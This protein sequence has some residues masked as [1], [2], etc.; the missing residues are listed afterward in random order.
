MY[1]RAAP[2]EIRAVK[3]QLEVPGAAR[4]RPAGQRYP[5][6]RA[7][8]WERGVGPAGE[9]LRAIGHGRGG[10][11][12]R[13]RRRLRAHRTT[14]RTAARLSPVQGGRPAGL[15]PRLPARPGT[16]LPGC[17]LDDV[18]AA[19]ASLLAGGAAEVVPFGESA[20]RHPG[21]VGATC[22]QGRGQA[23]GQGRRRV[24]G[25]RPDPFQ[26]VIAYQRRAGPD[27][28][29]RAGTGLYPVPGG[30]AS[31]LR[32]SVTPARRP[33]GPARPAVGGRG[34]GGPGRRRPAIRRCCHRGL[35]RP[36][37]CMSP[38]ARRMSSTWRC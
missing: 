28:P 32:A 12:A 4:S 5:L 11:V 7:P 13:R 18:L 1:I 35:E 29:S 31:R 27:Q 24:A 21:L 15:R 36:S 30:G 17:F 26:P 6:A 10:C 34:G 38:R 19:H 20:R 23:A 37:S 22:A 2:E 3:A 25:D 16:S 9:R 33:G 8:S 14:S